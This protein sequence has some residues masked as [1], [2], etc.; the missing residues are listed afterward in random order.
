LGALFALYLFHNTQPSAL[1]KIV[2]IDVPIGKPFPIGAPTSQLN[3]PPDI[4]ELLQNLPSRLSTP[5]QA[6][7]SHIL[8]LLSPYFHLTP[9][10]ILL[11]ALPYGII[12]RAPKPTRMAQGRSTTKTRRE[13]YLLAL[14]RL[15][16]EVDE[17]NGIAG[18]SGGAEEAGLEMPS[19]EEYVRAKEEL[20]G[21]MNGGEEERRALLEGTGLTERRMRE[22]EA[23]AM[24][25]GKDVEGYDWEGKPIGLD[26]VG[27]DTEAEGT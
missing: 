17:P 2:H 27:R 22:I 21:L 6:S 16:R 24:R 4:H 1:F 15:T 8:R 26:L 3:N 10:S 14:R 23:W 19:A 18:F 25:E 12:T 9:P 20:V 7:A 5:S 13:N 11:P